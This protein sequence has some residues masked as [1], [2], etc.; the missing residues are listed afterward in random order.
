M[1]RKFIRLSVEHFP[2]T[3]QFL[4]MSRDLLNRRSP[5]ATFDRFF[6]A[7]YR[8]FAVNAIDSEL[9]ASNVAGIINGIKTV[10]THNFVFR[11]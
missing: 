10:D 5:A 7:G 6:R 8:A 11:A 1:I 2:A 4:R 3:A 9:K